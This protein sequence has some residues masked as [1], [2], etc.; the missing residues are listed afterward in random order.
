MNFMEERTKDFHRMSENLY[1]SNVECWMNV[2]NIYRPKGVV[3]GRTT[4]TNNAHKA[5][6]DWNSNRYRKRDIYPTNHDQTKLL[7]KYRTTQ[8][9]Y[10]KKDH[11]WMYTSLKR[12]FPDYQP[13]NAIFH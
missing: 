2:L 13:P 4:T 3:F 10:S 7:H 11:K 12:M 8:T 6:L 9:K 5:Q 1:T